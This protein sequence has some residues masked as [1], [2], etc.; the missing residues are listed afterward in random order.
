MDN[1]EKVI[2]K[3]INTKTKTICQTAILIK[4]IDSWYARR[5]EHFRTDDYDKDVGAKKSS[6]FNPVNYTSEQSFQPDLST[7]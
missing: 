7:P 2:Q 6:R 4:D 1:S 5:Y 3:A